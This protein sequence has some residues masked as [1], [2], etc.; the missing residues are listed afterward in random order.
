MGERPLG[1]SRRLGV[2]RLDLGQGFDRG[3]G[4]H[5]DVYDRLTSARSSPRRRRKDGEAGF[6]FV[7]PLMLVFRQGEELFAE[8]SSLW[9]ESE[10]VR[11]RGLTACYWTRMQALEN[12]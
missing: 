4:L 3:L 8:R 1:E 2:L 7:A 6:K 12:P 9:D 11:R 5:V 10:C